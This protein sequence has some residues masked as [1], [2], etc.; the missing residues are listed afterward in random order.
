[1]SIDPSIN[2]LPCRPSSLSV[3]P[4]SPRARRVPWQLANLLAGRNVVAGVNPHPH[5]S[6]LF[7]APCYVT[8]QLSITRKKKQP[9]K[10]VRPL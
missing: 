10:H 8:Y 9:S 3:A 1:M 6:P 4:L 2:N 5:S 7:P